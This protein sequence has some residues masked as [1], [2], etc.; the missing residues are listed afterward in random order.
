MQDL[1]EPPT[2]T[3]LAPC[4]AAA[5]QRYAGEVKMNRNLQ[6]VLLRLL[7]VLPLRYYYVTIISIAFTLLLLL[8]LSL[9]LP[10]LLLLLLLPLWSFVFGLVCDFLRRVL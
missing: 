1:T 8:L 4:L 2:V 9:L 5:C 3:A 7:P 6:L 10:L